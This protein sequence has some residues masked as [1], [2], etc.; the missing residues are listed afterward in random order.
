MNDRRREVAL[1]VA[2]GVSGSEV[3]RLAMREAMF[4]LG[5]ARRCLLIDPARLL[6]QD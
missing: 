4:A 6:T 3:V 2:V 5:P 1:R